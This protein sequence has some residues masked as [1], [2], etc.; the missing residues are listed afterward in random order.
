MQIEHRSIPG[1]PQ[2]LPASFSGDRREELLR[3]QAAEVTL[4]L[5]SLEA[6]LPSDKITGLRTHKPPLS[7]FFNS[8]D[9][10]LISTARRHGWGPS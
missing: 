7:H 9:G 1:H 8:V 3:L 5:D 2:V 6:A 10:G 4:L